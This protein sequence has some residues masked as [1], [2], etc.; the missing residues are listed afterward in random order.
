MYVVINALIP[1]FNSRVLNNYWSAIYLNKWFMC[2]WT[3][4]ETFYSWDDWYKRISKQVVLGIYIWTNGFMCGWTID[5][6]YI[7]I[8]T[9]VSRTSKNCTAFGNQ[10]FVSPPLVIPSLKPPIQVPW[11]GRIW[12]NI[13]HTITQL[14]IVVLIFIGSIYY[15]IITK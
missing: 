12:D 11:S 2:E 4:E 13:E 5:D 8:Y 14:H 1:A 7:Y 3:I 15:N 10:N 9:S 6:G